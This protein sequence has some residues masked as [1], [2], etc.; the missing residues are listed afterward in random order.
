MSW[1]PFNWFKKQKQETVY[2]EQIESV[3][4]YCVTKNGEIYID[5]NIENYEQETLDRFAKMLAGLCSLKFS[6][7]T[8]AILQAGLEENDRVG[9]YEYIIEKS[10][11]YC[12]EELQE[13]LSGLQEGVFSEDPTLESDDPVVKPSDIIK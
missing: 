7:Q 11:S 5:I 12:K 8:I 6:P 3:I 1:N 4:S 2:K 9:E 10:T 13:Y